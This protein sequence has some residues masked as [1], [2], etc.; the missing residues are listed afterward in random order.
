MSWSSALQPE[1]TH[2]QAH[3]QHSATVKSTTPLKANRQTR[4]NN[5]TTRGKYCT[6]VAAILWNLK[7]VT[8]AN[9]P[10]RR[11]ARRFKKQLVNAICSNFL[12]FLS[13]CER[14][15]LL[16]HY[17]ITLP[18]HPVCN[19]NISLWIYGMPTYCWGVSRAWSQYGHGATLEGV[20]ECWPVRRRTPRDH[21]W[22]RRSGR[23]RKPRDW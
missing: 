14:K 22:P 2:T 5:L 6:Y 15:T 23:C 1:L 16:L 12:Q 19:C 8:E 3:T 9:G 10:H 21:C 7:T 4:S 20:G 18:R 17:S 11:Q 13:L